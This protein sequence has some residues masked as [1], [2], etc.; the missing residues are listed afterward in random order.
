M[1]HNGPREHPPPRADTAYGCHKQSSAAHSLQASVEMACW[2]GDFRAGT[3]GIFDRAAGHRE[4]GLGYC[5]VLGQGHFDPWRSLE[6]GGPK[7][8]IE[9][10]IPL[11]LVCTAPLGDTVQ[12][13]TL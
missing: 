4:T 6:P 10:P 5:F 13:Q 12:N 1:S 11:S 7:G 3:A 8:G 2:D 9:L